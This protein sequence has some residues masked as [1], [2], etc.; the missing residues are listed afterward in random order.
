VRVFAEARAVRIEFSLWAGQL[1]TGRLEVE[2]LDHVG[3]RPVRL[4]FGEDGHLR[5]AAGTASVDAGPYRAGAWLRITLDVDAAAARYDVAIDGRTV[6]RQAAF[7]E[8]ASTVERLSLRT[9]AFRAEP[10][11]QS[12]RY[13]VAADLPN[14]DD[15]VAPAVYYLDEFAVRELPTPAVR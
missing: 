10:T 15:P 3:H 6:V 1:E 13:A 9:G 2:V 14:P 8:P 5:T 12:D 4:A 7:A 11:R